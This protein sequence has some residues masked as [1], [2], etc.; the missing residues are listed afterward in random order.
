MLLRA[1]LKDVRAANELLS[2]RRRAK[3]VRLREGGSL[4][5]Q[6]VGDLRTEI[7]VDEQTN[8]VRQRSIDT[9]GNPYRQTHMSMTMSID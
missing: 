5:V 6:E 1:E 2:K 8:R 4:N 9:M 3:K 7:E